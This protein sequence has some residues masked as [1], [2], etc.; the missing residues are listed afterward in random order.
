MAAHSAPP[1]PGRSQARAAAAPP[2][3]LGILLA[4]PAFVLLVTL[5]V[6]LVGAADAWVVLAGAMLTVAALTAVVSTMTARLLADDA[7]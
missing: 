7:D 4:F 6:V 1:L 2:S 5:A 3:G